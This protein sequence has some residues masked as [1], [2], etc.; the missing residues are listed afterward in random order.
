[1]YRAGVIAMV[2]V[3]CLVAFEAAPHT[4]HAATGSRTPQQ[5]AVEQFYVS[6]HAR[7]FDRA[8]A[9][10][11]PRYR[12]SHPF[13]DWMS[14]YANTLDFQWRSY[15][16]TDDS[17]VGVDIMSSDAGA[18]GP[19][20]RYFSGTWHLVRGG[21]PGGWVLDSAQIGAGRPWAQAGGPDFSGFADSW[22][23]HG[24][25]LTVN[26]DGTAVAWYRT[27][28]WCSDDPTPP[29]DF[30]V[31]DGIIDGG[32]STITFT[33]ASGSTAYG[34]YDDGGQVTLTLL[35]YDMALLQDDTGEPVYLCG[36]NFS[37]LAPQSV[38][39]QGLCGA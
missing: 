18:S 9:F 13:G 25:G 21:A 6:L 28:S 7:A 33:S 10:F 29:C 17:T 20:T 1:M 2:L 35:P 24:Y 14:G 8:Y 12:A 30:F 38:V 3:A 37:S 11:S 5:N 32:H 34:S 23:H 19:V 4:A 26:A 22:G 16:S 27:Y 36:P 31:G 39:Q 15:P